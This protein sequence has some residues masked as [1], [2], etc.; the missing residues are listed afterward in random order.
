MPDDKPGKPGPDQA[1]AATPADRTEETAGTIKKE[2]VTDRNSPEK[3]L[4][5]GSE[6]ETRAS[7]RRRQ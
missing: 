2:Q 4:A 7:S 6:P 1:E 5:R 3:D